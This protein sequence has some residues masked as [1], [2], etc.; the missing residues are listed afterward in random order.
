MNKKAILEIGL[1]FLGIL[2]LLN[3]FQGVISII[4]IMALTPNT[5]NQFLSMVSYQQSMQLPTLTFAVV[6]YLMAS[7]VLIKFSAQ[8]TEKL[9]PKHE[10][11]PGGMSREKLFE[12]V[13]TYF[14]VSNIL[15]SV[16][17]LVKTIYG[18]LAVTD[19]GG[20]WL[21]GQ[22]SVYFYSILIQSVTIVVSF[23]FIRYATKIANF[24]VAKVPQKFWPHD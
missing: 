6:F 11:N 4:T 7:F 15:R 24:V 18:F 23:L 5:P 21:G 8:I 19:L 9:F 16:V 3:F 10:S 12:L 22:S 20:Y 2:L 13:F 1:K 14:G 17:P